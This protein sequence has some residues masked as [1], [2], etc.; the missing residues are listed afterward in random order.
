[1]RPRQLRTAG[2]VPISWL[3]SSD[4]V[5]A[6]RLAMLG[7]TPYGRGK[8]KL[9]WEVKPRG[10]LFDGTGLGRSA[11]WQDSGTAG[12]AF[13]QLIGSLSA[14]TL[15]H[16]RLRVLYHPAATPHQAYSRWLTPAFNGAQGVD[17]RTASD[18]DGDGL[19][20]ALELSTCTN[21][22][23]ADSDDDGIPDGVED[24]HHH[25]PAGCGQRQRRGEGRR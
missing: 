22:L 14:S 10:T 25:R 2:S 19:S 15:Y 11:S 5:T 20:D 12:H 9:E 3:G 16:W 4:S 1:V 13:S 18:S 24:A 21:P 6:F 7:R 23:D 8:V 17:F